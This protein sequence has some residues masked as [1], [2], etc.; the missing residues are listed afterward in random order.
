MSDFDIIVSGAGFGGLSAGAQL[1]KNGRKV[2]VLEQAERVGGCCSTYEQNGFRFDIGASIVEA[3][4]LLNRAFSRLGTTLEK[5]VD[6]IE[7]DPIYTVILSDGSRMTIPK[8]LTGTEEAIRA[9]DP[10]DVEGWRRYATLMDNFRNTLND[11]FTSPVVRFS[12]M[13]KIVK[14]SPAMLKYGSLFASS[15]QDVL[16][17]Y[18]K[19]DKVKESLAYQTFFIGLPPELAPG[20]FAV[21]PFQEHD[22]LYYVRGGMIGIPEALR[23]CGERAGMEVRL[24][25]KVKKV[26]IRK[27]RAVG[28]ELSDGTEISSNVVVS[29]INAKTLYLDLIG[30]EQLP[31]LARVGV[32]SYETAMAVPMLYLG[33]NYQPPL[34]SHHTLVTTP[35]EEMNDFWWSDYRTGGFTRRQFA[36]I[37]WTSQSDPHLA[38][39]GKHVLILTL[40]PSL[41]TCG[42]KSWDEAKPEMIE[43]YIDYY[44]KRCIPGLKDHIEV[45]EL[46][47]PLD[48]ERRLGTPDGAIYALRQDMMNETVFRPAAK[49][50]S[51]AGLYLV[52]ASTHP[53]GGVPTTIASGIVATDLIERYEGR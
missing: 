21:I 28:V 46:A 13:A 43:K 53:G 12:D 51:I 2:L 34:N 14:N 48:F 29:D 45:A 32:K 31:W 4:E 27:K 19:N 50:R 36:I 23:R 24:N 38:P 15:Y 7:C 25:A 49:S 37:S 11:F 41:R 17:K 35:M 3:P 26:L 47:T 10:R 16:N 52:G 18:F 30:A 22:G 8:S 42:R 9:I 44:S 39:A 33:V 20:I 40:P 1:A 5:E 6:L